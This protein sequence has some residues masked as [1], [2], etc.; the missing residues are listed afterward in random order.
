M[1]QKPHAGHLP[2]L[3]SNALC[4]HPRYSPLEFRF[5]LFFFFII[6]FFFVF[7]P[8]SYSIFLDDS[9]KGFFLEPGCLRGWGKEK[10]NP[11]GL[12]ASADSFYRIL[13]YLL[14]MVYMRVSKQTV[15]RVEIQRKGM[16]WP[17]VR[18]LESLTELDSGLKV[19]SI[20]PSSCV[21][22]S[23]AVSLFRQPG[24]T[25]SS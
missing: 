9:V 24:L 5:H 22:L 6:F 23:R 13:N 25:V 11:L 16:E 3:I 10:K 19:D 2:Y 8:F 21:S 20:A 12:V 17:C 14:E 18:Y 15:D 4:P 1:F 7:P